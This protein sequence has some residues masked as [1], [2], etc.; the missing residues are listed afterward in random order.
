MEQQGKAS[1]LDAAV[2]HGGE[3]RKLSG[4]DTAEGQRGGGGDDGGGTGKLEDE[5]KKK[6]TTGEKEEE[7]KPLPH[8]QVPQP[9]D[10]YN[11]ELE[12]L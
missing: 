9:S 8:M 4:V 2:A 11:P 3:P 5:K 7:V 1:E 10:V 6:T 12:R